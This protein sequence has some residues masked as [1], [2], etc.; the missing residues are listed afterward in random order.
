[1]TVGAR[2]GVVPPRWWCAAARGVGH[3]DH[4]EQSSRG[5]LPARL[6][7]FPRVILGKSSDQD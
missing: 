5:L 3:A 4:L 7:D 1:M 6:Y 2:A